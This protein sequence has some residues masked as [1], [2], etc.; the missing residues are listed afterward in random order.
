VGRADALAGVIE[1]TPLGAALARVPAWRGVLV[2][3]YHRIGSPDGGHDASLWSATGEQLDAQ[4]R[5]L[6]RHV[7]VVSGDELPDA[8]AQPRGRRVALTFD[9]GYRDNYEL[10]YPALRAH[11]LP[12]TF[13][14][15]TGFLD[16]P[17]V[18]WWDEIGWIVRTSPREGIDADGWLAAPVRFGTGDRRAATRMLVERYWSLPEVRTEP[19]LRW[20]AHACGTGRADAASAA[21]TWMTWEMVREMR[22]GGM[23]FGAH[24]VEHPVLARC[25]AE[26]QAREIGGSVA[27]LREQLGE[28][29]TLFAYPVGGHGMFDDTTRAHLREAGITHAFSF[30]GGHR[31]PGGHDPLD[32]PR[33]FAGPERF[34]CCVTLPQVF[35][36]PLPARPPEAGPASGPA[37]PAAHVPAEEAAPAPPAPAPPAPAPPAPAPPVPAAH[38]PAEEAEPAPPAPAAPAPAAEAAPAPPAP[39]PAPAAEAE[40]APGP[41]SGGAP[42]PAPLAPPPDLLEPGDA[43]APLAAGWG[44]V[45]RRG[46]VWSVAAFVTSKALSFLSILVLA[47]LLTPGEFGVVAAVAAFIALIELGS[48]L[49]MKPAVVYEQETGVSSRIQTAFTMNL[50]AAAA[51]TAIGVLAAPLI[52]GFFGV[53]GQTGLFELGALNLLLTGLG[54]IHDGLLLRDMS[55]ARRIRPQVARDVVRLIVSVGL[56]LAGLGALGLVVGFLAGTLAWT[57]MQWALT[58]LRPRL[59]YDGAIARSMLAY[60]APAAML[61]FV[62]T[63]AA[64]ADVFAIGHL[65]DSR[66]LGIYTIAYRLPEVLL[67]SVA[68][69]LGIV[70]FPALARRRVQDPAGLESA[71]L[72]LVRY[73]ALYAL[74]VA[75]G[76]AVLSV[77]I[78]AL[79]F[80]EQW[81]EAAGVLVPITVA[82]AVMTIAYPLGDLLKATG[83]QGLMVVFNLVQIPAVIAACLIAAPAGLLAV[84]WGMVAANV[85]FTA[86]LCWA[87]MRELK[88]GL[89]R[90]LWIC[91]PALVAAAGVL[92]GTGA[93]RLAWPQPSLPALV[94]ATAAGSLGAVLA[95]R[96]LAPGTYRDV[97]CQA[98]GL[99][100]R[101]GADLVTS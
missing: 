91:A 68:Y 30:H 51:L 29:V 40:P 85:L 99:R 23:A 62:S 6:A 38:V 4:L 79:L 55:F 65:I 83:Q 15:A 16:R 28:P 52:A 97:V 18:A 59:S 48:D 37:A 61:A 49:G 10:A 41:W 21:S 71:T 33:A 80:G 7:D 13:F 53:A 66:A 74:P 78:V 77:P 100:R 88:L 43:P 72:M 17:H 89:G 98:R 36:R 32:V 90:L 2:L 95:L 20:L 46:I 45:V 47:R 81:R 25:T 64:R 57:I 76:M 34:R 75:A 58:P 31:R 26:R 42:A 101:G 92:A 67:A 56:A 50:A 5:F 11:G 22:A 1:R 73:Q 87:V 12:A 35:A 14:L 69:T 86:M 27:R 70:A 39:A 82:A 60:G 44:S 24:T 54:N 93:V 63:I 3:T 8:L 9:D 96:A 84:A 19:Y 94:A